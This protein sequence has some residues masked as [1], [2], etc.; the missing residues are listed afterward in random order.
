MPRPQRPLHTA[1]RAEA[2]E[3]W[4]GSVLTKRLDRGGCVTVVT[5]SR[6]PLLRSL[7]GLPVYESQSLPTT[8]FTEGP[9]AL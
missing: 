4:Q 6:P 1:E 3:G 7:G 2:G 5:G 9:T 8:S